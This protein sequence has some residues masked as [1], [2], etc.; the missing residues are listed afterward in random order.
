MSCIPSHKTTLLNMESKYVTVI[1]NRRKEVERTGVGTICLSVFGTREC[2]KIIQVGTATPDKFDEVVKSPEVQEK[3]R[4]YDTIANY[5][6]IAGIPITIANLNNLLENGKNIIVQSKCY[7]K[8]LDLFTNYLAKES[9]FKQ[10]TLEKKSHTLELIQEFGKMKTLGDITPERLKEF[11]EW[12]HDGGKRTDVTVYVYHKNL[13]KWCRMAFEDGYLEESP[14]KKV[15]FTKGKSKER[16][17][18][19]QEELD[20]IATLELTGNADRARDMFIFAAYTGLALCDVLTFDYNKMTETHN[21][22]VYISGSRLKTSTPFFTPI[23]KPAMQV[24]KKRNF[25]LPYMCDQKV[26]DYLKLIKDWARIQKP[27][28][29]HIARHTFATLALA[30]GIPVDNVSK[31]LGHTNIAT[32]QIYAK[33]LKSTIMTNAEKWTENISKQSQ[34]VLNSSEPAIISTPVATRRPKRPRIQLSSLHLS[35]KQVASQSP[36]R[37]DG[38]H[39]KAEPICKQSNVKQYSEQNTI[40]QERKQHNESYYPAFSPY[41]YPD[42]TSGFTYTYV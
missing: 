8:T 23:M 6:V 12:L 27:L 36:Q 42:Y 11:D 35:A 28:T 1:Y 34:E 14:Y 7:I 4:Y 24:L 33:T 21:G 41:Y 5:M 18:L 25:H 31:M 9:G 40:H 39:S 38:H 17:P 26:N 20:R 30:N 32:T 15:H 22:N 13:K 16:L 19:S 2:R 37:I 10:K 3:I 29:F